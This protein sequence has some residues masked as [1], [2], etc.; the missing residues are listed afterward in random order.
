MQ[1]KQ[2]YQQNS[3]AEN[4]ASTLRTR[5]WTYFQKSAGRLQAG[6][7]VYEVDFG[8]GGDL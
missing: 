4:T 6:A 2:G 7:V 5:R 1:K 8:H 3:C